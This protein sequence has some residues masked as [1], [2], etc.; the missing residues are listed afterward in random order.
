MTFEMK[1]C[2][3]EM[4]DCSLGG[5]YGIVYLATDRATNQGVAMKM[6]SFLQAE[7]IKRL[8]REIYLLYEIEHTNIVR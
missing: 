6:I 5:S 4:D 8:S 3:I 2:K 7:I 1:N